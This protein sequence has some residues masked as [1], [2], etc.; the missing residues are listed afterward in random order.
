[1]VNGKILP[2]KIP[3]AK[4]TFKIPLISAILGVLIPQ[5]QFILIPIKALN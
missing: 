3:I 5:D 1:M 4:K 2:Q